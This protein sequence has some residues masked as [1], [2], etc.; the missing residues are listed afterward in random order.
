MGVG[1][2]DNHRLSFTKQGGDGSGKCGIERTDEGD[3]VLGVLYAMDIAEKPI[4]DEIEGVGH[5]YVDQPVDVELGSTILKAFTYYS[6]RLDCEFLPYD[7]YKR[8]VLEGAIENGFPQSYVSMIE[9]VE[10]IMDPDPE[11]RRLNLSVGRSS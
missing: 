3:Y 11:R 5:G 4:L 10:S 8:F 9:S 6:A 2:L 7:W 1:K